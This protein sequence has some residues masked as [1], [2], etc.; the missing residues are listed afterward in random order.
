MNNTF[1]L[2]IMTAAVL[3]LAACKEKST[4]SVTNAD[5][6]TVESTVSRDSNS[7]DTKTTVDPPG[8]MNKETVEKTHQ[9]TR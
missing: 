9:E 2:A 3:G 1:L 7:V 6:T 5:G 4:T 8:L